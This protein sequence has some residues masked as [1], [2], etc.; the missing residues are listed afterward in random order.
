[1]GVRRAM[2][3]NSYKREDVFVCRHEAHEGFRHRV[4]AYHVLREKRCHPGGC[5]EFL[6]KCKL[7]G[8]GGTCPKGYQHVGNNCTQCR[9]YDEEKI[10]RYP[11]VVL[12]PGA[13][14][15]FQEACRRFDEWLEDHEGRLLEAGGRVTC[16]RPHLIRRVDGRRSSLVLRGFLLRLE[17][18][19]VGRDGLEDAFYLRIGRDQQ[20][21]QRIAVGDEIEALVRI[22]LDRGRL[23]GTSARRLRIET[24]SGARPFSWHAALLDR[25][26]AVTVPGQPA[27]CLSCDRGVLIDVEQMGDR[28][29]GPRREVLC[30]EGI[31]RP[32]ECPYEVLEHERISGECSSLAGTQLGSPGGVER[33]I[34][35]R[36][37]DDRALTGR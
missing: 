28:R 10:H 33:G 24:R 25:A 23:V 3:R 19:Y 13:Y 16:I 1:M 2:V 7:L 6:W 31:G 17:P 5:L 15:D 22:V 8:K 27:R 4:S 12:P 30:L 21:R 11:E 9:H 32:H 20:Q 34:S 37:P 35:R 18:A 14:R 29:G 26:T 36:G